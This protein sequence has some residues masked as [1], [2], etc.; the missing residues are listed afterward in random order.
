MKGKKIIMAAFYEILHR[1]AGI[2][3]NNNNTEALFDYFIHAMD[4]DGGFLRTRWIYWDK[5]LKDGEYDEPPKVLLAALKHPFDFENDFEY[6][7]FETRMGTFQNENGETEKKTI[8]EQLTEL[9]MQLFYYDESNETGF[10]EDA[11]WSGCVGY[12][13]PVRIDLEHGTAEILERVETYY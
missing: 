1:T 12:P 10:A 8:T 7:K 4:D 2:L 3:T 9:K 11:D 6:Y 13:Y 5:P